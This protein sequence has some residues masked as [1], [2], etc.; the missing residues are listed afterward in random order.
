MVREGE[1]SESYFSQK[2]FAELFAR[3]T[4][5]VKLTWLAL[6]GDPF[7]EKNA[8]KLETMSRTA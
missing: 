5:T 7:K 3:T 2:E 1:R 4:G 8:A 6:I